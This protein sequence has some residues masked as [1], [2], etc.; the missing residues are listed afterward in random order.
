MLWRLWHFAFCSGYC[1]CTMTWS[2]RPRNRSICKA[3]RLLP[4][5]E[6]PTG[7]MTRK[8]FTSFDIN[9]P[10]CVSFMCFVQ[11]Q[12]PKIVI[13]VTISR[14]MEND[15]EHI[16][17]LRRFRPTSSIWILRARVPSLVMYLDVA[18]TFRPTHLSDMEKKSFIS[19]S[20][21]SRQNWRALC[22]CCHV[23]D[24]LSSIWYRFICSVSVTHFG[25]GWYLVLGWCTNCV[26]A[27]D[28]RHSETTTKYT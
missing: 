8:E 2:S 16:V 18:A 15:P 1:H 5:T 23:S 28:T 7:Q 19:F 20:L 22:V 3:P 26:T 25:V 4:S 11:I 12:T 27:R 9:A 14:Q 6:I 17:M 24:R 21:S 13:I 10:E